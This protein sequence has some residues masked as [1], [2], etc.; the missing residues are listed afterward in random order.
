MRVTMA[1]AVDAMH[2]GPI[3]RIT[4]KGALLI[5]TVSFLLDVGAALGWM[6]VMAVYLFLYFMLLLAPF[7]VI[8]HVLR[9]LVRAA[10]RVLPRSHR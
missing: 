9:M 1:W 10:S 4:V 2:A 8:Y 3:G 5:T 6:L 7:V